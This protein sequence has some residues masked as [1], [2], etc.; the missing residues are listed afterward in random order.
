MFKRSCE[1][2]RQQVFKEICKSI[3]KEVNDLLDERDAMLQKDFKPG[4][5]NQMQTVMDQV[6]V[7]SDF[8]EKIL[9]IKTKK[10]KVLK[11]KVLKEKSIKKE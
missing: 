5:G 3:D 7:L 10:K 4:L 8:K 1:K 6:E 11:E 2:C 9:K